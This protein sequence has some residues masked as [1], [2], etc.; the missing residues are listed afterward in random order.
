[1]KKIAWFA[2]LLALM[3]V[4][5][6]S[7][8][9]ID[10]GVWQYR[11]EGGKIML[12][13]YTGAECVKKIEFPA[14]MNEKPVQIIGNGSIFIWLNEVGQRTELVFP[15]TAEE[16]RGDFFT[17][18][19]FGKVVIPASVQKIGSGAFSI[20]AVSEFEFEG[21]PETIG[22]QAFS[23]NIHL[24]TIKIPE[25][26]RTLGESCFEK[27]DRMTKIELPASLTDIGARCFSGNVKL[28]TVQFAPGCAITEIPLGC[29]VDCAI[30]S[31]ELPRTV[32]EIETNAFYGCKNLASVIIP[33]GVTKI[34]DDA[35]AN[36]S[37]KLVLTVTEGSYAQEWA[38]QKGLK[39]KVVSAP[40]T[41]DVSAT[42]QASDSVA[43]PQ[44]STDGQPAVYQTLRPGSKGQA[45]LDARMKLYQLGYFKNKPTQ[46]EYTNNMKD[47]VKR[48]ERDNG[49]TQDGILS[50]EDQE[51]LF[52]L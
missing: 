43:A 41:A 51:V 40:K 9:D 25:G 23:Q 31:I 42:A 50:P 15:D 19:S 34:A 4:C 1:M 32:T 3:G 46:K 22:D 36:C 38:Q 28:A 5:A 10:N 8:A 6:I 21:A 48:F 2:L 11:T 17:L 18:G 49:L 24:K 44:G 52:S 29:F 27:C 16:I 35:F 39:T 7:A 20:A 45:V 37:S 30:K 13:G 12:T 26:T 14:E 47:Y 33:E